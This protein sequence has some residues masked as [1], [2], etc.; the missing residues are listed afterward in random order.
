MSAS[1]GIDE[2]FRSH[3]RRGEMAVGLAAYVIRTVEIVTVARSTGYDWLLVDTEHTALGISDV[4][5]IVT[6]A[7]EAKFPALVRV[8]GPR[9]PDLARVLDC[10]AAGL[11]VPHVDS[12][13]E[14]EHVAARCR[15]APHGRRSIPGP[16][17]QLGFRASGVREMM[18]A[19]E[20]YTSIVLMIESRAGL[21]AAPRIAA[22]KG[23]DALMIGANDLAD[24][25]GHPGDLDHPDVLSAFRSVADACRVQG[26]VFATIGLPE[27]LLRS[28]ALD[29][30]A[31][32][33]VA[34]NDINLIIDAGSALAA[35]IR[36]MSPGGPSSMSTGM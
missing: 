31:S 1:S 35:R 9:H 21:D 33:I 29:L 15:F 23:V 22:V 28:H 26:I 4:A 32:M 36:Q 5:S 3:L 7:A 30:G 6:A 13:E 34:T 27:H 2:P 25:L 16:Q 19:V 12:L 24:D 20:A 18:T 14:A 17:A 8:G 11:I 10:G